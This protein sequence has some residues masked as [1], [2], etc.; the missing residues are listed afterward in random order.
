MKR[1]ISCV[2]GLFL[3]IAFAGC[4]QKLGED[5]PIADTLSVEIDPQKVAKI[6]L[7][8]NYQTYTVL[9]ENQYAFVHDA[10]ALINGSYSAGGRWSND[11]T[12]SG[13]RI[14]FYD[15]D[16]NPLAEYFF[17]RRE[18]MEGVEQGIWSEEVKETIMFQKNGSP[19]DT[20]EMIENIVEG[21][22]ICCG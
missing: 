17:I 21:I 18:G 9:S 7:Y 11:R 4:S 22:R 3:L 8:W 10:V 5:Q 1:M 19:D 14:T 16:G 13:D 2:I 20:K 12:G 15:M 6:D